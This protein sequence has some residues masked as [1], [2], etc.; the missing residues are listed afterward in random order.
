MRSVESLD[1]FHDSVSI[2]AD[3]GM[4]WNDVIKNCRS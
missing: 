3:Q 1:C 2:A 4:A